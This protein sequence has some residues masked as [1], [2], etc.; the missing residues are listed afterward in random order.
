VSVGNGRTYFTNSYRQMGRS[1]QRTVDR[2][3]AAGRCS[4]GG[5]HAGGQEGRSERVGIRRCARSSFD[6]DDPR[7]CRVSD[8]RFHGRRLL[9]GRAFV[10]N[11]WLVCAGIL[12]Y[13][14]AYSVAQSTRGNDFGASDCT[15]RRLPASGLARW[16]SFSAPCASSLVALILGVAGP[17]LGE[18]G[19]VG[20]HFLFRGGANRSVR[21]LAGSLSCSVPRPGVAKM[22]WPGEGAGTGDR[23]EAG[24]FGGVRRRRKNRRA[25]G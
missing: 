14:V 16:C 7:A 22:G 6:D 1:G 11:C 19:S 10:G 24:R 15:W 21:R 23:S 8:R 12:R 18:R 4:A 3:G 17:S 13:G 5:S 25:M 9:P 20:N 2:R